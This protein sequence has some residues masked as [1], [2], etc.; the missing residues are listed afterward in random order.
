MMCY[1]YPSASSRANK[2]IHLSRVGFIILFI[3]FTQQLSKPSSVKRLSA[4]CRSAHT[5][6]SQIIQSPS[7]LKL[8]GCGCW[9]AL[10]FLYRKHNPDSAKRLKKTG[11]ISSSRLSQKPSPWHWQTAHSDPRTQASTT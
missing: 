5:V 11:N 6:F 9:L 1:N 7:D 4:I 8:P 2:K 10:H 3:D